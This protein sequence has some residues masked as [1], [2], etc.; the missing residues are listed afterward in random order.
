[1]KELIMVLIL[2]VGPSDFTRMVRSSIQYPNEV[3]VVIM[4]DAVVE[5]Y[6][7]VNKNI[8]TYLDTKLW[9][10][11][12]RDLN[13]SIRTDGKVAFT[14]QNKKFKWGNITPKEKREWIQ[15][16]KLAYKKSIRKRDLDIN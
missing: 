5:E 9:I 7:Y 15:A 16:L 3:Q 14:Y 13:Y 10:T 2:A 12:D 1:M 11:R 4:A 8:Y 6:G